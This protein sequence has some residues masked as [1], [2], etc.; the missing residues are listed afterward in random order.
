MP[1]LWSAI[2]VTIVAS[3]SCSIGKALQKE[4]T[5]HLPR[6]SMER[7]IVKQ[8]LR[9]RMW[10]L[11]LIADVGGGALQVT[12]FALAPVSIV[13]PVSG[14]GL[15]GLSLYSHFFLKEKLRAL[16]WCAVALAG[17][18]TIGLGATSGSESS[19]GTT[20]GADTQL[21]PVHLVG[22]LLAL[23]AAVGCV[24][25]VRQ[26]SGQRQRRGAGGGGG[27]RSGSAVLGLQAGACFG[28]SAASCRTGFLLAPQ[29]RLW[30]LL[31]LGG[32][33]SL[34]GY[35]FVLQTMG[36]KEGNTVVVCTLAAVS[37]MVS[38]VA[39]G[40][41]ALGETL[42]GLSPYGV[43]VRIASWGGILLGVSALAGGA[44]GATQLGAWALQQLPTGAWKLL[45]LG[46]ALRLKAWSAEGRGRATQEG[47][48][49]QHHLHHAASL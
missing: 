24:S 44:G 18:G 33:V 34:S 42:G 1:G 15:V 17:L 9:N 26:R 32:S 12:A 20:A 40:L 29:H 16:E 23:A 21:S 22:V 46:L 38:G 36:L 45:P 13:Q 27:D 4:G 6:M 25:L 3:T 39:V 7:K 35:G 31:G 48:L 43:L 19:G 41:L 28:L 2:I 10:L 5:R 37:A 11:G 47:E 30:P 14:V 8:Y 49:P